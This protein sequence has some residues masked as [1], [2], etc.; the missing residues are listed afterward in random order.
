MAMTG[1]ERQARYIR[2]LKD[3][4][5]H[6]DVLARRLAEIEAEQAD[7]HLVRHEARHEAARRDRARK[8]HRRGVTA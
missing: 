3:R 5:A 4:A 8:V 1:A 6:A 7:V 2:K